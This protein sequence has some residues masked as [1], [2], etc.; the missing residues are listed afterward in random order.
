ML[1]TEEKPRVTIRYIGTKGSAGIFSSMSNLG[2]LL[3]P[4]LSE[5][6]KNY[7]IEDTEIRNRLS[8]DNHPQIFFSFVLKLGKIFKKVKITGYWT[9]CDGYLSMKAETL[10]EKP[11]GIANESFSKVYGE[12]EVGA[13]ALSFIANILKKNI[14]KLEQ[15]I[16][17]NSSSAEK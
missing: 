10:Q 8:N 12:K 13:T 7:Q 9:V 1:E 11:D 16:E 2:Q 14:E 17:E 3:D 15:F 5:Y 4:C 6:F